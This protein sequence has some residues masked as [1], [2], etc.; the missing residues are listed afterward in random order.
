MPLKFDFDFKK[1][2]TSRFKIRD[3]WDRAGLEGEY[4]GNIMIDG[5]NWAIV[6]FDVEEDLDLQKGASLLIEEKIWKLLL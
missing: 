3:G 4:F 5:Q 6:L 1:N 2:L